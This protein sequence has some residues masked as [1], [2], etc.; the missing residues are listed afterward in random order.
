MGVRTAFET[1]A[2]L[3]AIGALVPELSAEAVA[4]LPDDAPPGPATSRPWIRTIASPPP[5][6]R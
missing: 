4:A 6:P 3:R 5:G 1:L 2:P